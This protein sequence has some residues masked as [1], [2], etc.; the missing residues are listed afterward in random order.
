MLVREEQIAREIELVQANN[1]QMYPIERAGWDRRMSSSY[2]PVDTRELL[3]RD[4]PADGRPIYPLAYY[5]SV[6]EEVIGEEEELPCYSQGIPH[7]LQN[8]RSIQ[9]SAVDLL[10]ANVRGRPR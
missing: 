3:F 5:N 4:A 7:A 1:P 9:Y 6:T 10:L 8:F 2:A